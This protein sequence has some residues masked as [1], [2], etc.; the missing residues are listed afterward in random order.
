[1][2][3]NLINDLP[4]DERPREKLAK[5]GPEALSL[6]ELLAIFLRVG[7]KGSSAIEV[8]QQL[9]QRHGNLQNLAKLSTKEIANQHG[10]GPAKAAQITAAFEIGVRLAREKV[11]NTPLDT[12]EKI[13]AFMRPQVARLTKESL[14]VIL[15]DTRYCHMKTIEVSRGSIN[16]TICH[17][18]DILHHAVLHQSYG[19]IL[20]HN[21]PSGNPSPSNADLEMTKTISEAA[22]LLQIKFID[23]LIIGNASN[24][25]DPYYS[26]REANLI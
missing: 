19:F 5:W 7:V 14:F 16:Q 6:A 22:D 2:P 25:R 26:F 13:D 24:H 17:P 11:S 18:R 4:S 10:I 20:T 9:I 3:S 8:A 12:P 21:H 23:H 15:V 1:M